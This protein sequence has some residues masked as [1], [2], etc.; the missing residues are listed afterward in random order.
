MQHLPALPHGGTATCLRCDSVLWRRRGRDPL[1]AA[2]ALTLAGICLFLVALTMPMISVDIL[3]QDRQDTLLAT[4]TRIGDT[5]VW[6][7]GLVVAATIAVMPATKLAATL[8][9]LLGLRRRHKPAWL[10]PLFGWMHR[11]GRWAMIEVFLLGVFVAY[12]RLAAIATVIPGSALFALGGFMIVSAA[13]DVLM[14]AETVWQAIGPTPP[15]QTSAAPLIGCDRCRL[16]SALP[17]GAPCPRCAAPLRQRRPRSI[18]TTWALTLAAAALYLPANLYPVMT[19]TY[20]GR[21]APNTI[22]SGA[23]ELL[24]AGMW[25]LALLVFFA[26]ITVPVLKLVGLI[27]MLVTTQRGS[28]YRLRDRTRLYRIVEAVGRWSMIDVFMIAILVALV[29]VGALT[30]VEPGGGAAAFAAV[31]ILTMFAASAFD[32]RL[33]W[34][35]ADT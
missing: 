27:L 25:P 29:H 21:G 9:V 2:L 8:A 23:A 11:I 4:A 18:Q 28:A 33:M 19:V 6:P 10:A 32:P 22:L 24:A 34:D 14:D 35:A 20:F 31:V 12:S 7:L 16:A 17:V 26:S 3:G 30:T 13:T 15:A 1:G 5:T